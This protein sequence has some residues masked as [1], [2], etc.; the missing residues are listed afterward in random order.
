[1]TLCR[2][3]RLRKRDEDDVMVVLAFEAK[4]SGVRG[5][6]KDKSC[7]FT[8]FRGRRA[9]RGRRDGRVIEKALQVIIP[10]SEPDDEL[11]HRGTDR[12]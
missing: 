5:C 9:P 7:S 4:R 8:L 2:S 1:M 12:E 3:P 6:T 10:T 11:T